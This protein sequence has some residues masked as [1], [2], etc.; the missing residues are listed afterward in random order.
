M[1]GCQDLSLDRDKQCRIVANRLYLDVQHVETTVDRVRRAIRGRKSGVSA[2][3]QRPPTLP[4]S[5]ASDDVP[6]A[7]RADVMHG[8]KGD[9]GNVGSQERRNG[10]VRKGPATGSLAG[11][12]CA[13]VWLERRASAWPVSSPPVVAARETAPLRQARRIPL[14]QA[15]PEHHPRR[16]PARYNQPLPHRPA[17]QKSRSPG[18]HR[19]TRTS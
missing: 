17:G 10:A 8:R 3:D 1:S 11:H 4:A 18:Q 15:V 9:H 19:A 7:E 6:S 16:L 2:T 12:Y 14:P 5:A 13:Q